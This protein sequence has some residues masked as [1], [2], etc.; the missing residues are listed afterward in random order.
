ME[1]EEGVERE[2][3]E[4]EEKEGVKSMEVLVVAE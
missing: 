4:V 2:E 3:V 1:E